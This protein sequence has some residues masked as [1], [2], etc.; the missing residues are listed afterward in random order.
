MDDLMPLS[1]FRI[2]EDSVCLENDIPNISEG[3]E[4]YI[5]MVDRRQHCLISDPRFTPVNLIDETLFYSANNM[6]DLPKE[7]YNYEINN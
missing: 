5:L 7:L 6:Q 2:T 4:D 1:E 3:R